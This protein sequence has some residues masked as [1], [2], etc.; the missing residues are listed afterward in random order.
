MK[1]VV[2]AKKLKIFLGMIFLCEK[3]KL[4]GF[5]CKIILDL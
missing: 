3:K 2:F 4:R 5:V 1:K